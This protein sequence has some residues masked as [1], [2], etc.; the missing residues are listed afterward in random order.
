[1]R[2][3]DDTVLRAHAARELLRL[4]DAYRATARAQRS[5]AAQLRAHLQAAPARDPAAR[6]A[7][8]ARLQEREAFERRTE[9]VYAVRRRQVLR[10]LHELQDIPEPS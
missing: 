2:I 3:D 1:M 9:A 5:A 4:Y 8:I 7:E 6:A 10:R